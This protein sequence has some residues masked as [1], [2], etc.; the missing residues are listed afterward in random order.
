MIAHQFSV[1]LETSVGNK[2]ARSLK[3]VTV[4]G[5]ISLLPRDRII[6]QNLKCWRISLL[7]VDIEMFNVELFTPYLAKQ[8]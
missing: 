7:K 3:P 4:I 6:A 8:S 2:N 1:F 5:L